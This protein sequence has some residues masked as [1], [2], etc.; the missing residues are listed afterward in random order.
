MLDTATTPDRF[1]IEALLCRSERI[2][3]VETPVHI[4]RA[5]QESQKYDLI[6]RLVA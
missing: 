4:R 5:R 2:S 6:R 1:G 3:E